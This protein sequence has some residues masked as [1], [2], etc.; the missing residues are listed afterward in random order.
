MN[1]KWRLINELLE[2]LNG[3]NFHDFLTED[4]PK[5]LK[6]VCYAPHISH[7]AWVIE[8]KGVYMCFMDQG[9]GWW[10][11]Y[12]AVGYLDMLIAKYDEWKRKRIVERKRKGDL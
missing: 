5:E 3:K 2:R 9:N 10:S 6:A 12:S 4:L 8:Y 11:F 1:K 7:R